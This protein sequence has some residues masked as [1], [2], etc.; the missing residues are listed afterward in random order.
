MAYRKPPGSRPDEIAKAMRRSAGK[1]CAVPNCGRPVPRFGSW[2]RHHSDRRNLQGHPTAS[3]IDKVELKPYL[4]RASAFVAEQDAAG[5]IGVRAAL[6]WIGGQLEACRNVPDLAFTRGT[7][8]E[9]RWQAWRARAAREG[10]TAQQVLAAC[11]AVHLF[12]KLAPERVP[13]RRFVDQQ[14]GSHVLRLACRAG[15]YSRN[16]RRSTRTIGHSQALRRYV[17]QRLNDTMIPLFVAASEAIAQ[18][19]Q[20]ERE[21]VALHAM[22]APFVGAGDTQA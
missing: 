1:L 20:C 13:D 7:P 9:V 11:V 19:M 2:C 22:Q 3:A 5:H 8:L 10:V 12:G 18:R 15:Y 6:A 14:V 17:G 21:P 16:G 4:A